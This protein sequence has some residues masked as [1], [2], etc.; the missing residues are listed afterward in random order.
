MAF[1]MKAAARASYFG[2][3]QQAKFWAGS[4]KIIDL[5]SGRSLY[6]AGDAF[7]EVA[8]YT[9]V[10]QLET[11]RSVSVC[12]I[13][14]VPRGAYNSIA[15]AFPIGARTVLT[16]LLARAHEVIIRDPLISVPFWT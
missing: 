1:P 8:F 7:G 10:A 4:L 9:E 11:V 15:A 13:L 3:P 14:V 5:V 12:R 2:A 6:G 16:N